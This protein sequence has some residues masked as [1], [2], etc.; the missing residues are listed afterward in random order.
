MLAFKRYG[1]P[2]NVQENKQKKS[3]I[4]NEVSNKL[5]NTKGLWLFIFTYK[6][7]P[8]GCTQISFTCDTDLVKRALNHLTG[9]RAICGY[10]KRSCVF[11]IL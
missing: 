4:F 9:T 10:S 1:R 6:S 3:C 11:E 8:V 2:T 5:N 7:T